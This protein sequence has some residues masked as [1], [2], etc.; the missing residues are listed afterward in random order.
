VATDISVMFWAFYVISTDI[1]NFLNH[2]P[3][4]FKVIAEAVGY[5]IVVS[6]PTFLAL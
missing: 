2:G 1:R 5:L 4:S 6:L 3:Q